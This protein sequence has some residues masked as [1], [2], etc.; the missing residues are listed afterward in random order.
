M[1]DPCMSCGRDTGP[2]TGTFSQRKRARDRLTDAEG[3]L[4]DVCQESSGHAESDQ[5]APLSGR[6]VV[7]DL[8]GGLPIA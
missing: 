8:P 3:F 6:Y 5:W 7:I 4:C 1:T 2:G